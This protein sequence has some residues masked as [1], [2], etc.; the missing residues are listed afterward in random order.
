M[1]FGIR[2]LMTSLVGKLG[3]TLSTFVLLAVA[4]TL[5]A[6]IFSELS[7]GKAAAI[8]VAGSLRMQ[9]Y[10]IT[11]QILR[12][13][14]EGQPV[15]QSGLRKAIAEFERRLAS[16]SLVEGVPV[17][18]SNPTRR[19]YDRVSS[20]WFDAVKPGLYRA[21][22]ADNSQRDAFVSHMATYVTS[23]DR[24]VYRLERDLEERIQNLK[25]VQGAILFA[26]TIVM[27]IAL[28][29]LH[30]QVIIPMRDLLGCAR[31]VRTGD[32]RARTKHVGDDELGQLGQSFNF[33][34]ADL[35]RN[36]AGLEAT[37]EEKAIQLA[38][39]NTSLEVL[40][41]T[42]R[43]LAGHALTQETLAK[44][45]RDIERA[46][47]IE[48]SVVCVRE[49]NNKQGFPIVRKPTTSQ[50]NVSLDHMRCADCFVYGQSGARIVTNGDG[51]MLSVPLTEGGKPYGVMLVRVPF[52]TEMADWKLKLLESIGHHIGA[53]L[54]ASKRVEDRGRLA[55]NEERSVIARELH[56]SLAQ[57]LSYLNIQVTRLKAHLVQARDEPQFVAAA[58]LPASERINAVVEELKLGLRNAYRQL[59]ELLTTFRLG[60]NSAGLF[61]ALQDAINEFSRRTNTE[62]R[63]HNQLLGYELDSSEQIHVLQVVRE[64]LTNI[65]HH[66]EARHADVRL[67]IENGRVRVIV[68]DDGIGLPA[69]KP[70]EHHYGLAIMHDRAVTLG[71]EVRISRRPEGGTRVELEFAPRG[72]Y[73]TDKPRLLQAD[74][75]PR[76]TATRQFNDEHSIS[77]RMTS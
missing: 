31:R 4:A 14:A 73:A 75:L 19:A 36:Y 56:D 35:S 45:V 11:A 16:P 64:A 1:R 44:I 58:P 25:A 68:E 63:L 62:F 52:G 23:V 59:R 20:Q 21:T 18:S 27:L 43:R 53:A 40:Y 55:L 74:T 42:T 76:V 17:D 71:G 33:M 67:A 37:V 9:T 60:M 7:T 57:S 32:F 29:L 6:T 54:A 12:V 48:V 61:E 50:G 26:T 49:E 28:Y 77:W 39:S 8:N 72:P 69:D 41:N 34:V 46:I 15:P 24:L 10:W 51:R 3:I 22:S 30:T 70:P 47:G 13:S 5:S 66:A 2:F 65:E 38:R